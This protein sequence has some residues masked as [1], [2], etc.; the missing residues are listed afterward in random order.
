[1]AIFQQGM[2]LFDPKNDTPETVARKRAIVAQIMGSGRAPQTIGEGLNAIGDGIVA[3]VLN[4]RADA[5]EKAGQDS[6]AAAWNPLLASLGGQQFPAAPG[7]SPTSSDYADTRVR[8]SFGD[9]AT[10]IR[11]G[12]IDRGMSPQVADAFVMNFQ[13]ESGLN[14][15][16]NERNPIVPGSRGGFGLAQWTGPRRRALEAFA[17]QRGTTPGD[18]NT[19]LDFLMSE[20]QGPEAKAWQAIQSAPTTGGAAAAIVNNFLRPAE[21]HRASRE[22]Q[23]LANTDPVQVASLDQS[24]GLTDFA[25]TPTASPGPENIPVASGKGDRVSMAQAAPVPLQPGPMASGP[26]QSAFLDRITSP[27]PMTGGAPMPMQPPQS[28]APQQVAQVAPSGPDLSHIPVTAGGNA[29]AYQPG[30]GPSLQMLMQA[31]ANPWLNDSQ[32]GV[33]QMLLKQQMEQQDPMRALDMDYRRAQINALNA[34]GSGPAELGLNP[35]YGVDAQGNPV[36]IQIGKDGKAVQTTMPDGVTLSKEPIRMDAGTHFV[37]LDPITRQPVGTIPKENYQEAFDKGAGSNAAKAQAEAADRLPVVEDNANSILGMIDSL[38]ND[39]YLDSMLGPIH[40][41]MP[42]LSSEAARVQSKM[43]QI[44]GQAF[45]QAFN[46]LRGG[47]QI[48]NDEGQKATEAI[49]RLNTDQN[50]RDYRQAL[51]ELR[52]IVQNGVERA[53]RQAGRDGGDGWSDVGNGVKIRVKQ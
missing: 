47:G 53:R 29:G 24:A 45:L 38:S 13:D 41:R 3:N 9:N 43:D 21:N 35:Q 17:A 11:Q 18:T 8:T 52:T 2:F 48:S 27:M 26:Q 46:T 16:I 51:N 12:L 1:M 33:I 39:P 22:R 14:P 10:E 34:K 7:G 23:Y 32:R 5:A 44:T 42:N 37:L 20:L 15:G 31:A 25:P 4:R 49:A 50:P 6:A 36:L 40:S 19:Q 30:Q 28:G